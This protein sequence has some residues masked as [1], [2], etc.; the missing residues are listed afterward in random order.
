MPTPPHDAAQPTP[1]EGRSRHAPTGPGDQT[2]PGDQTGRDGGADGRPDDATD[3]GE[4]E[5]RMRRSTDDTATRPRQWRRRRTDRLDAGRALTLAV[6]VGGGLLLAQVAAAAASRLR[7]IIILLLLSLFLSFAMEP[8]VQWLHQRGL[9]RGLGTAIVFVIG[10]LLGGG[11]VLAMSGLV[12]DQVRSLSASAPTLLADLSNQ[13]AGLPEGL[14]GPVAEFLT[15]QADTLPDRLA[16][17]AGLLGRSAL[18]ISTTIVGAI[19]TTLTVTLL[20]FYLVADGPRLRW[21]LSRRL[22]AERQREFMH[23]WELAIHKTGGY[24]YSRLLLAIVSAIVHVVAFGA[25]D[26]RYAAALGV[27]MGI[28]SSVIPVVGLYIAGTLPVLV[29]IANPGTSTVG[30]LL[31]IVAYQQIENYLVQPKITKHTLA[32]HPALAFVAVLT[33]AAL[34]GPVGALLALPATAIVAALVTAY[35]EEHEVL[36]HGLN[37][38][39]EARVSTKP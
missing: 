36:E 30:I 28:V 16:D 24:V 15:E 23:I 6:G 13:A 37:T 21:Q 10:G 20:T 18:G 31:V 1:P 32:L 38:T 11:F 34:L 22:D 12:S 4:A 25:L 7:A 33:G 9:R 14:A 29:A 39:N 3:H 35:A 17:V 27:W 5:Q 2:S 19:F 26:L 8:A